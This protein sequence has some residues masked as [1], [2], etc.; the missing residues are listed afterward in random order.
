[1]ALAV[2]RLRPLGLLPRNIR[3][4]SL[5][6]SCLVQQRYDLQVVKDT[7]AL[8]NPADRNKILAYWLS[9][10]W[11]KG[12]RSQ[13][14]GIGWGTQRPSEIALPLESMAEPQMAKVSSSTAFAL[15]LEGGL[16]QG[17]TKVL[18]IEVDQQKIVF[19]RMGRGIW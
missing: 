17:V 5:A 19:P 18:E 8:I 3:V 11:A 4:S 1:M 2:S 6:P 16:E 13:I 9:K 12:S 7:I 14:D 10:A 15:A